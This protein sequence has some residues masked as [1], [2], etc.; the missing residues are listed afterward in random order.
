M[1]Q[2]QIYDFVK[3]LEEF[4]K[5]FEAYGPG[6]VG[7]DLELGLVKM[8]VSERMFFKFQLDAFDC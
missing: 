8:E 6:S 1:T 5:N 7:D 2:D 4:A 3:E